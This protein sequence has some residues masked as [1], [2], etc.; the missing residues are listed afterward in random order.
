[1]KLSTHL[2]LFTFKNHHYINRLNS[3]SKGDPCPSISRGFSIQSFLSPVEQLKILPV[4]F[5]K[6]TIQLKIRYKKKGSDECRFDPGPWSSESA[7]HDQT[8]E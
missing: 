8:T 4:E 3:N 5:T 1:M 7:C 6:P 2:I